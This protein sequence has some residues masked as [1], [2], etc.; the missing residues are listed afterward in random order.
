MKTFSLF[1]LLSVLTNP[2]NSAKAADCAMFNSELAGVDMIYDTYNSKPRDKTRLISSKD[3]K[4]E[5]TIVYKEDDY[6]NNKSILRTTTVLQ[7]D[8]KNRPIGLKTTRQNSDGKKTY[9]TVDISQVRYRADGV[10][11]LDRKFS[12]MEGLDG[13]KL[14]LEYDRAA[15]NRIVPQ[16]NKINQACASAVTEIIKILKEVNKSANVE[17]KITWFGSKEGKNPVFDAASL[18]RPD[19]KPNNPILVEQEKDGNQVVNSILNKSEETKRSNF[20]N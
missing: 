19:L 11:E 4:S 15:C 2:S 10:C 7:R 1:V 5:L 3:E 16:I 18:C 8:S 17:G 14:R 12:S 13:G 20:A 9:Q 6:N